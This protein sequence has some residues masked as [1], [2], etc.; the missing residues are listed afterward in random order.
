MVR[1]RI[2]QRQFDS[3]VKLIS[4]L[5]RFVKVRCRSVIYYWDWDLYYARYL[6]RYGFYFLK[7]YISTPLALM[8]F[9]ENPTANF[10]Y[11]A[12][13]FL[14]NLRVKRLPDLRKRNRYFFFLKKNIL[15]YPIAI[16]YNY[17]W[18]SIK[19][20][21]TFFHMFATPCNFFPIEAL[22]KNDY[23]SALPNATA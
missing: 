19:K 3:A 21:N 20:V 6:H 13:Y 18:N 17:F 7:S 22:N 8:V 4:K 23:H 11:G 1:L 9:L 12:F 15:A 14:N 2:G 10:Y 5:K 16:F